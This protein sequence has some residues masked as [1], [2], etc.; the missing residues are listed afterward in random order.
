MSYKTKQEAIDKGK[1]LLARF[2]K[3]WKIYVHN[4][5]GWYIKFHKD[6]SCSIYYEEN[7]NYFWCLIGYTSGGIPEWSPQPTFR[8]KDPMVVLKK[9]IKF[10]QEI[11]KQ[12]INNLSQIRR[13]AGMKSIRLEE[14]VRSE[15][16]PTYVIRIGKKQGVTEMRTDKF[17][18]LSK[19]DQKRWKRGEKLNENQNHSM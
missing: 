17:K 4:N 15:D 11:E 3:G 1:K 12:R 14:Y 8:S 6:S 2:P 7:Y 19:E 13:S 16:E 10:A 9:T 18:A 5:L